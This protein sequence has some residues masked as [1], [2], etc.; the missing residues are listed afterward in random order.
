[1]IVVDLA[2]FD[3]DEIVICNNWRNYWI[4]N[5]TVRCD[6][7]LYSNVIYAKMLVLCK[8]DRESERE[9]KKSINLK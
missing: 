5:E 1:M 2:R 8:C 3:D 9:E 7:M 4:E 6:A